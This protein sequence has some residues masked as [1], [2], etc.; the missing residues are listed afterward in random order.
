MITLYNY[1]LSG[2]CYKIRL[3]LSMLGQAYETHPIAF[4]PEVEHKQPEFLRINPLGQLPVIK[5]G[6]FYLRDAQAILV[7]LASQYDKSGLWYPVDNPQRLGEINQWLAFADSITG[8][9]SAARLHDGLFYDLDI[10]AAREGAHRLFRILDEHLWMAE[11]EGR[12][13]IC[14]DDH[15]TI[16][17][18]ACFPYVML[19]EEGGIYRQDYPAIRRW[20]DRVKR[21]PGFTVMSG[22]FPAGPGE[23]SPCHNA[24]KQEAHQ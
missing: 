21:L 1:E 14:Q 9:A 11:Q 6:D 15:P 23:P 16:A 12:S 24:K 20:T 7:Y 5:D 18:I 8:T 17:D 4:Y 10:V 19:A 2:N 22:V 13:W 3:F